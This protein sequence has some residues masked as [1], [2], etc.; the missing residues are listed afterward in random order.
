MDPMATIIA[1]GCLLDHLVVLQHNSAM[2]KDIRGSLRFLTQKIAEIPD[3][4]SQALL[5][6]C[7][8]LPVL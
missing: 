4:S 5:S 7:S 6:T 1:F 8:R 3:Q 2:R